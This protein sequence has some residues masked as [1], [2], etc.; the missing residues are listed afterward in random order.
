MI[1][2]KGRIM[3]GRT[4]SLSTMSKLRLTGSQL[5][6]ARS[7]QSISRCELDGL[8]RIS[9]HW[10]ER[11]NDHRRVNGGRVDHI[12][13]ARSA[14]ARSH[15]NAASCPSSLTARIVCT[16]GRGISAGMLHAAVSDARSHGQ[17]CSD[18]HVHMPAVRAVS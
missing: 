15:V 3:R 7:V 5:S 8:R 6:P 10:P 14:P 17:G 2:I 11:R 4:L 9:P 18:G 12:S 16:A 13:G 1:V